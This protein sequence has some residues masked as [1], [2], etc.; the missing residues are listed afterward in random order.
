MPSLDYTSL[1]ARVRRALSAGWLAFWVEDE[2]V[3]ECPC[4]AGTMKYSQS[5]GYSVHEHRLY[6]IGTGRRF[7]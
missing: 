1:L 4:G 2:V 6:E 3:Y 7:Q 5:G